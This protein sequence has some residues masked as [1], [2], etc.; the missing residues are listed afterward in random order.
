MN[1][2]SFR[3]ITQIEYNSVTNGKYSIHEPGLIKV[4]YEQ[5]IPDADKRLF[6]NRLIRDSNLCYY[7]ELIEREV[8]NGYCW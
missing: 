2:P 4:S 5:A 3:S 7:F 8:N 6:I 1:K